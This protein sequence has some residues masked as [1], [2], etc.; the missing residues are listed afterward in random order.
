MK[1]T[2]ITVSSLL[3][4]LVF[5]SISFAFQNQRFF[6]IEDAMNVLGFTD[7]TPISISPDGQYISYHINDSKEYLQRDDANEYFGP[8]GAP[9]ASKGAS[10]YVTE[11][12]S[13]ITQKIIP[14]NTPSWGASWSPDGNDLAFYST[15]DGKAGVWLWNKETGK[16]RKL[17]NEMVRPYWGFEEI[18]WSP[19]GTK[20]LVKL[21]PEGVSSEEL[22]EIYPDRSRR[23]E[24]EVKQNGKKV[25]THGIAEEKKPGNQPTGNTSGTELTN[26]NYD[27]QPVYVNVQFGDL[28]LIDL[29]SGQVTRLDKKIRAQEYR[30]SPDGEFIIYSVRQPNNGTATISYIDYDIK[31]SDLSGNIRTLVKNTIQEYGLGFSLSHDGKKLAYTNGDEV[32]VLN[33]ETGKKEFSFAQDGVDLSRDYRAPL[34]YENNIFVPSGGS[35]WQLSLDSKKIVKLIDPQPYRVLNILGHSDLSFLTSRQIYLGGLDPKTKNISILSVDLE[36]GKYENLITLNKAYSGELEY[37]SLVSRDSKKVFLTLESGDNPPEIWEFEKKADKLRKV[38]NIN[39]SFEGI[40]F[41]ESKLI[42]WTMPD[43]R[44]L[45]GALMLPSDYEIGKRYPLLIKVYAGDNY[46]GLVNR[47]GFQGGYYNMQKFASRGY[48][49]LLPDAPFDIENPMKSIAEVVS[50]AADAAINY[51]VADP[52]KIALFGHSFGGY[53]VLAAAV[54]SDRYAA[55]VSSAGF[56][57]LFNRYVAMRESGELP[58]VQWS[59][60]IQLKMKTHPWERKDHYFNNSPFFYLD[61]VTSPVLLLHGGADPTVFPIRA[62]ETFAALKR[63]NKPVKMVVYEGEGHAPSIFKR[64]NALDYHDQILDWLQKYTPPN[65]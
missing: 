21:L 7:R 1:L 26:L 10:V 48:A 15:R 3:I 20:I 18:V 42:S 65:N 62:E 8:N 12:S 31:I 35:L 19:D 33:I 53:T 24:E 2:N 38:T 29:N 61:R 52:K 49:V 22:K 4:I 59:E 54:E 60:R 25:F 9:R 41:G 63:L 27:T 40:K 36:S 5:S 45:Q 64:E 47:F 13:G 57:N 51:G 37:F 56:S 55:V 34:W 17:N 46:S 28:S 43:G 23:E 58:F 16:L 11:I 50:K 44:E 6:E 30:F 14:G 32:E 39:N